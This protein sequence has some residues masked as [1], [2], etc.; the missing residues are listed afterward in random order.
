MLSTA[1]FG[2]AIS[3]SPLL[4][5][6][7]AG[8]RFSQV[9]VRNVGTDTAYV[10]ADVSK[11]I[12]PGMPNQQILKMQDDPEKIGLIALPNKMIIPPHQERLLRFYLLQPTPRSIDQVYH[13]FVSP[14]EGEIEAVKQPR[15][16]PNGSIGT[17]HAGIRIILAYG[18]KIFVRPKN[19]QPHLVFDRT[20]KHLT[21][22]NIGN[23]NVL[24]T[25]VEQCQAGHCQKVPGLVQRYYV[26]NVYSAALPYNAPVNVY[27]EYMG[28]YQKDTVK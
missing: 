27:Q 23:S 7:Q 1:A 25:L 13:V 22:K 3:V 2:S 4:V 14:V 26:G 16:N 8:Q 21:I 17:V 24:V 19:P 15:E 18:I 5:N 28:Q 12:N 9:Q 6:M 20:G 11:V 10:T